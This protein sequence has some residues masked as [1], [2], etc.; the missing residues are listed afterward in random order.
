MA[1]LGHSC[2]SVDNLPLKDNSW[3]SEKEGHEVCRGPTFS[4]GRVRSSFQHSA[5]AHST[6][7]A[8]LSW[9]IVS[10]RSPR[11]FLT[12]MKSNNYDQSVRLHSLIFK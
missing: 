8:V 12:D 10:S 6:S 7:S 2:A 4:A 9:T 5:F 11:K 1:K 3:I